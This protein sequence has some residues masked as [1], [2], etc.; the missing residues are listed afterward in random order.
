VLRARLMALD[1][2]NLWVPKIIHRVDQIPML[3]TG[4]TD[5][6]RCREIAVE[7]VT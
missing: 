7:A 1:V 4:K 5:L 6:K 3:G 2:P